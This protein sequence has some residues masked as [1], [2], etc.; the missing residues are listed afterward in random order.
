M[1]YTTYALLLLCAVFTCISCRDEEKIHIPEHDTGVNMRLIIEP[2]NTL[3]RF[4]SVTTDQFVFNAY[5]E[6]TDLKL[7]EFLA[8]Y[9]GE[10]EVIR[11]YTQSDFNDGVERVVLTAADF[12]TAFNKPGFTNGTEGGNFTIRPRVTLNDDRVYPAYVHLSE[13]D[14]ILNVSTSI[15][16]SSPAFGAFTLQIMTSI[17]CAPVDISGTYQVVSATGTSTDGCCPDPVSISGNIVTLTAIDATRFAISD[18]SG[19]LYFEWYDVYG[20]TSPDDSPGT[21][22]YNCS[23]VNFQGTIEPFET[24]V[25]GG[26]PVDLASG[27]ITY[28]WSNG[29]GDTGTVILQKQ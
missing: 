2:G 8:T 14:S 23:E 13:G 4:D 11:T 10:T 3:I 15:I 19:G 26:G 29:Y 18:F 9:Q 6:N 28:T 7:V 21:L 20:I 17:T 27:R 22:V 1:K 5:S 24:V 12:A 25:A 16:G